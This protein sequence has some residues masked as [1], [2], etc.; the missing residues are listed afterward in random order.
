MQTS[1]ADGGTEAS[2][3]DDVVAISAISDT[4]V[5]KKEWNTHEEVHA[6]IM[7][8]CGFCAPA[9]SQSCFGCL[10]DILHKQGGVA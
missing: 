9:L 6:F 10:I 3:E 1:G 8:A 2:A 4:T 7:L 5:V